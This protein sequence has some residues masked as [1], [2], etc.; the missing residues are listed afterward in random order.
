MDE[1]LT[2]VA[3]FY[4]AD[5]VY[6][7]SDNS[8]IG[9]RIFQGDVVLVSLQESVENGDIAL[10]YCNGEVRIGKYSRNGSIETLTPANCRYASIV[11]DV[12]NQTFEIFGKVTAF[13]SRIDFTDD[14]EISS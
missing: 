14:S 10:A 13:I 4:G 12:H 9:S 1:A 8:M 3:R 11:S 5:C 2:E 7:V 6:L